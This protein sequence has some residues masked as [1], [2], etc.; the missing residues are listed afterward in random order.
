MH[1]DKTVRPLG[2]L[3]TT[4]LLGTACSGDTLAPPSSETGPRVPASLNI[5]AEELYFNEELCEPYGQAQSRSQCES[6]SPVSGEL[7]ILMLEEATRLSNAFP[8]GDNSCGDIGRSLA[9]AL[10]TNR[11]YTY[12]R[13]YQAEDDSGRYQWVGGDYHPAEDE[14]H[15]ATGID[16]LNPERDPEHILETT[17]H[18]IGHRV[19]IHH[20]QSPNNAQVASNC[21]YG[22]SGGGHRD[23]PPGDTPLEPY[24]FTLP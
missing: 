4:L 11:V 1:P 3:F 14:V 13:M 16:D 23:G 18:E 24:G 21:L 6:L 19:G 2:L 8:V 22:D 17:L 5:S 15:V 7:R 12:D 10:Y 9:Q 20:N